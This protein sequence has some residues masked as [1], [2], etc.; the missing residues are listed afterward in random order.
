MTAYPYG[1]PPT[2]RFE[3][4]FRCERTLGAGVRSKAPR[5]RDAPLRCDPVAS[6]GSGRWSAVP[7]MLGVCRSAISL[8]GMHLSMPE[9]LPRPDAVAAIAKAADVIV[10]V[11]STLRQ[12]DDV[13]RDGGGGDDAFVIAVPAQRFG[14]ETAL[15]LLYASTPSEALRALGRDVV[16]SSGH[17]LLAPSVP[18]FPAMNSS[19]CPHPGCFL[20][21]KVRCVCPAALGSQTRGNVVRGCGVSPHAVRLCARGR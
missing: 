2:F 16:R 19:R 7:W 10:G 12:G 4:T 17:R 1:V 21:S 11:W 3:N 5:V 6:G 13:V 15:A 8:D 14:G 20:S 9:L 18:A